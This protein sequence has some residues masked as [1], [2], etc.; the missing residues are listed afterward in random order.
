MAVA[1]A[2]PCVGSL[3]P[4]VRAGVGAVA[5]QSWVNPYIGIWGL[6]LMSRGC[7]SNG[8]LNRLLEKDP[9]PKLR[10]FALVT[11]EGDAA[12]YTG[13]ACE[14]WRGHKTGDGYAVAGNML[15]GP[16]V[17]DAMENAFTETEGR[18]LAE[19]LMLALEAGQDAGGDK[20]GKV[21]AALYVVAGEDYPLWDL[22]VDAHA[23]PVPELR[24]VYEIAR[25]ELLPFIRSLP[26]RGNPAGRFDMQ[27]LR[28]QGILKD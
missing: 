14:A 16:G 28:D 22:R 13:E 17:I 25:K 23:D 12:A 19:R 11:A 4:Y 24:R 6:D 7:D 1:T 5:S 26:T 20:R 8:A 3:V 9:E 27:A 2:V 18:H 15:A 10:Q 21:S